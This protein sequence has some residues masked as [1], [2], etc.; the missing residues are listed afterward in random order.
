MSPALQEDSLLS[1]QGSICPYTLLI[2]HESILMV[3]VISSFFPE[4]PE[5]PPAFSFCI[6]PFHSSLYT[7]SRGNCLKYKFKRVVF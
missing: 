4:V 3:L 6:F 2:I 7:V 5:E 1:H